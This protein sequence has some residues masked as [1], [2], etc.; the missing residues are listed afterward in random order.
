[1][2]L[3]ERTLEEERKV[4]CERVEKVLGVSLASAIIESHE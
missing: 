2:P 1:L 4:A 3:P